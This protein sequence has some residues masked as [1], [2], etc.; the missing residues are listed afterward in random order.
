MM[1][2]FVSPVYYSKRMAGHHI[3]GPR[4]AAEKPGQGLYK[5][6]KGRG[7]TP[8]GRAY[9]E[10]AWYA[11]ERKEQRAIPDW[12]PVHHYGGY[13]CGP[14][15]AAEEPS[16]RHYWWHERNKTEKCPKSL[17]ER[18][19]LEREKAAGRP[20]EFDV[21]YDWDVP[22]SVYQYTFLDGDRYIGVTQRK[23][24]ER[25][26]AQQLE[27][28]RLGEKLRTGAAFITDVL[29]VAADKQQ[30]LRIE[31]ALIKAGN[32]YGNLLNDIHNEEQ[33]CP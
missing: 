22:Y 31:R 18:A 23:P 20:L 14:A 24:E 11:A 16:S 5:W 4:E 1:E 19:W 2:G 32:P 10:A 13:Q 8:C 30:A 12:E 29:C 7:E 26:K 25:W 9:A 27:N 6:H 33:V 15:D 28:S 3:C 17:A 21:P